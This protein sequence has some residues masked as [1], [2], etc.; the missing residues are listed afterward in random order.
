MYKLY[1]RYENG[2]LRCVCNCLRDGSVNFTWS[3]D[4][5]D[6]HNR[7][8]FFEERCRH[9]IA[10][11][12]DARKIFWGLAYRIP[13]KASKFRYNK[14]LISL[15]AICFHRFNSG[16]LYFDRNLE[17]YRTKI[18]YLGEGKPW[19]DNPAWAKQRKSLMRESVFKRVVLFLAESLCDV[20]NALISFLNSFKKT[21]R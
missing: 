11:F 14:A 19:I 9:I 1:W 12:K 17:N 6:K 13:Y 10:D 20:A 2:S 18:E 8:W 15:Y 3:A 7:S 4:A 16:C 5:I 21:S